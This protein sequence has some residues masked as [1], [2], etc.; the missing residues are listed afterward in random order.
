MGKREKRRKIKAVSNSVSRRMPFAGCY[1]D[2]GMIEPRPGFFTVMYG[3]GGIRMEDA[4]AFRQKMEYF[5]SSLPLGCCY[6]FVVHNGVVPKE[7]YLR[8]V[9]AEPG[10]VPHADRYNEAIL[11][12]MDVGHNNVRRKVYFVVGAWKGTAGQAEGFFREKEGEIADL[13][14]GVKLS[15][16]SLLERLGMLY[17][18]FHPGR[19]DF[20]EVLDLDGDGNLRLSNLKY[21]GMTMKDLVAPEGWD[22]SAKLLNAT[23]ISM[24]KGEFCYSRTLFLNGI[25]KEI[26]SNV[27]SDLTGVSG[28][29]LFSMAC[30]PVDRETGFEAASRKVQE[31]TIVTKRMK[32]ETIQDRKNRAVVQVS[33]RKKAD[34]AAYFYEA[35]QG[36]FKVAVASEGAVMETC[37]TI[38]LYAGTMEELD[39]D[40]ELLKLSAAKFA[41]SVKPLD[42]CQ[43]EGFCTTLPLCSP[44][45]DVSRF[46]DSGRLAA[47]SPVSV[48]ASDRGGG[49]FMG[50]NSV[51]DNLIF[52][53]RRG[54]GNMG[55]VVVGAE[56]SGKTF[57][58]KREIF[59]GMLSPGD[60]VYVVAATGEYDNFIRRMGGRAVRPE[61]WN[62][63]YM[64]E[65]Y[66]LIEERG[67]VKERFLGAL[68]AVSLNAGNGTGIR[69]G[70]FMETGG[71][72][73]T[74]EERGKD[75]SFEIGGFLQEPL[76]FNDWR[77]VRE[78]LE[79]RKEE[80]PTLAELSIRVSGGKD[81][82]EDYFG[83]RN[84]GAD[85]LEMESGDGED[86]GLAYGIG[87]NPLAKAGKI[88]QDDILKQ[89]GVLGQG[90]IPGQGVDLKRGMDSE[91]G[92][93]LFLYHAESTGDILMLMDYLWD[94]MIRDRK[95]GR[96]SW[97]FIEPVDGLLKDGACARYLMKYLQQCS[98]FGTVVTVAVQDAAGLAGDAGQ[99]VALEELARACGYVKLLNLGPVERK[100]LAGALNIP[101]ALLPYVSNVEPSKGLILT[102]ASNVPFDDNFLGRDDPFVELFL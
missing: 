41:C 49:V 53:D 92:G 95:Q 56:H 59:G 13:F 3:L 35:A 21:L 91:Q 68:L 97:I 11:E 81:G 63:F 29:M 94:G 36:V 102:S 83:G 60:R 88:S 50:L 22:T 75:L 32:R 51:N 86:I 82:A 37:V 31:N 6:Q 43:Y 45:V 18:A 79:E 100:K 96:G 10:C 38:T 23:K 40:T 72:E 15:R 73:K 58:M 80:Y 66:G 9:L 42:L 33:S 74:G 2:G 8:T 69:M 62:P 34:E 61:R 17:Q 52:M 77:A 28:N 30:L 90:S 24:G 57:Q 85:S 5:F 25:P 101:N 48:A 14:G 54:G 55:G 87:E 93:R 44:K 47:L 26:S 20:G 65:G 39:R 71:E 89:N 1:E 70:M 78:F 4:A 99:S 46:L 98:A 64:T 84:N 19:M 7:S 67:K 12:N 76:D 27:V 16:L